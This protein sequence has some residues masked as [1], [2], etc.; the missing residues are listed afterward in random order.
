MA[1]TQPNESEQDVYVKGEVLFTIFE[2]ETEHFSIAKIKIQDTNTSYEEKEIVIK[3]HFIHL[4]ESTPYCF[5]G[6]LKNHP[7]FGTQFQVTS[8]QTVIPDTEDG[9]IAYLCSDLF[10]GVGEKTATRIVTTL[11]ENAIDIILKHPE[12]LDD[13]P[14]L[15]KDKAQKFVETLK[16]NQ[17]FEHVAVY[18]SKYDIGLKLAQKIY[19]EYKE[20][21]IDIIQDDPYK[22]V[23]DI[24]GF[25][26]RTAD[27]MAQKNGLSLT[28]PNRIGAGCIYILQKSVQIGHVYLPLENCIEQVMDLLSDGISNLTADMIRDQIREMNAR[29]TVI[30]M[31]ENVYLP[32]LYYAE[33][34]FVSHIQRLMKQK[35]VQEVPLADLMKITGDI[36]ETEILSYGKDQFEA[37]RASLHSKITIVTGGP[38]TGKTTV[39]K[40]I[41]HAYAHIHDVALDIRDYKD[42]SE[43]PFVLTAP[44]GRAAK[45]LYESTGLPAV[46]IHRLLGWNG[47]QSFEKNHHD[48]L[49]GKFLIVDEFSMVDIWL[50]NSLFKA[51]PDDMQVL[52]VGDEDQLPSVGPGQVLSDLLASEKIPYIR[53]NEVYRQ[54]EG[55]KIIDLAHHIKNDSCTHDVLKND[56]DFSFITC[57]EQ[58]MIHVVTTIIN[59]AFDRG[60][61]IKDI[62]V[63]APIYRSRVGINELNKQLQHVINPKSDQK[64]EIVYFDTIFRVGDKVIQLINQPEDGIYNGDIGEIVA[65]FTADENKENEE[66]LVIL[67]EDKEIVYSKNEYTNIMHA[68]CISIHKSQGSEF[69]IVLMPV[70]H[71]YNRMLRKNLLYTAITRSKQSLIICGEET[72]FL[73]GVQ[74][75]DTNRR[76]TSLCP[77]L[78]E[79]LD[80]NTETLNQMDE[81]VEISPYDFM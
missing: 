80:S 7:K 49:D 12:S 69:P 38:G 2:N 60:V 55:S 70:L 10:Y 73:E 28:H 18:L 13:V 31:D 63:L 75:L 39:I 53:L 42:E 74:T 22:L 66:Q 50:A 67:Y 24:E 54:K 43:Y 48:P 62:Q 20:E 6:T 68:Y 72:S 58:Q 45:R 71:T 30:M 77:Q 40:G 61:D 65:I 21:A 64:R 16:E 51:I 36:E 33:D 59:K 17:G 35:S 14:G 15:K 19:Q 29:K 1:M 41:L 32:S 81:D 5:F 25:G 52:L 8:Y 76:Y 37:I 3:G 4:Q 44:T 78:S 11:G 34:G 56:H 57:S 46:T 26:F 9:L 47:H 23:F 79:R 27:R